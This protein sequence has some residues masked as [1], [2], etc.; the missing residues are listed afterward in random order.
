MEGKEAIEES[1]NQFRESEREFHR[2]CSCLSPT[3]LDRNPSSR[4]R[5]ENMRRI[6]LEMRSL[7]YPKPPFQQGGARR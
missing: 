7:L 4:I 6:L 5:L 1:R 2:L 3:E